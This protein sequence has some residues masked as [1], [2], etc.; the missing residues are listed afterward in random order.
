MLTNNTEF[1][2]LILTTPATSSILPSGFISLQTLAHAF[3]IATGTN[4]PHLTDTDDITHHCLQLSPSHTTEVHF[5]IAGHNHNPTRRI[6]CR[7]Y[8]PDIKVSF[9]TRLGITTHAAFL[10]TN[11][12]V[13]PSSPAS[14]PPTHIVIPLIKTSFQ[15]ST[16][17]SSLVQKIYPVFVDPQNPSQTLI[18]I[19][20]AVRREIK[21]TQYFAV[22]HANQFSNTHQLSQTTIRNHFAHLPI[23]ISTATGLSHIV[24]LQQQQWVLRPNEGSSPA[25]STCSTNTPTYPPSLMFPIS[26]PLSVQSPIN[27]TIRTYE[28]A[29]LSHQKQQLSPLTIPHNTTFDK[30]R[31]HPNFHKTACKAEIQL[32]AWGSSIG[33]WCSKCKERRR[34]SSPPPHYQNFGDTSLD[35][36][37]FPICNTCLNRLDGAIPP[38]TTFGTRDWDT[39]DTYKAISNSISNTGHVMSILSAHLTNPQ[40]NKCFNDLVNSDHEHCCLSLLQALHTVDVCPSDIED[41]TSESETNPLPTQPTPIV[42]SKDTTPNKSHILQLV[43]VSPSQSEEGAPRP[44]PQPSPDID[45]LLPLQTMT[46]EGEEENIP[47]HSQT[48]QST[49]TQAAAFGDISPL[50]GATTYQP[51]A[52]LLTD[53]QT[54]IQSISPTSPPQTGQ[55]LASSNITDTQIAAST[56][57]AALSETSPLIS[58]TTYQPPFLTDTQT[59]AQPTLTISPPQTEQLLALTEITDTQLAASGTTEQGQRPHQLYTSHNIPTQIAPPIPPAPPR[60]GKNLSISTAHVATKQITET[61]CAAPEQ[62][63]PR[64]SP[65]PHDSQSSP[66]TDTRTV[67]VSQPA[68]CPVPLHPLLHTTK[69]TDTQL[70]ESASASASRA[71]SQ[72]L[73]P[74]QPHSLL[75]P[76]EVTDK[77]LAASH[78]S[79]ATLQDHQPHPTD[80]SPN[81]STSPYT[82]LSSDAPKQATA[83]PAQAHPRESQLKRQVHFNLQ[84]PTPP[85]TQPETKSTTSTPTFFTQRTSP[86]IRP[87]D[88]SSS[89]SYKRPSEHYTP[90]AKRVW[91]SRKT[92]E[93]ATLT[94]THK[95]LTTVEDKTKLARRPNTAY[96]LASNSQKTCNE[97]HQHN[98]QR[99][100]RSTSSFTRQTRRRIMTP[101]LP[102][103]ASP[104][105]FAGHSPTHGRKLVVAPSVSHVSPDSTEPNLNSCTILPHFPSP[106][107]D[108]QLETVHIPLRRF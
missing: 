100:T 15:L 32:A 39:G 49:D 13:T 5:L 14:K 64:D 99:R 92:N 78:T 86:E 25:T 96:D 11:C 36:D 6:Y 8:L 65:T 72:V 46:L 54:A 88:Y 107:R 26:T 79:E 12:L 35:S 73:L 47:T 80:T 27:P 63:T 82:P 89:T 59:A 43:D 40:I 93:T 69:V 105:I 85:T 38:L 18:D 98:T 41:S 48:T 97:K 67:T 76:T 103:G 19:L 3:T 23:K 94:T 77:Q 10:P 61:R 60:H 57:R 91:K 90:Q 34:S 101:V 20:H 71:I 31:V 28:I 30:R 102:I 16:T 24:H 42:D 84:P 55:F 53:T 1:Q 37:S 104:T 81:T 45:E 66:L 95:H 106:A 83:Q 7:P 44:L 33:F 22:L 51:H 21:T 4:I 108:S 50:T 2:Q 62:T 68:T 52:H 70:A 74:G 75:Q 56:Q 58:S 87:S 17:S 29:V 9:A